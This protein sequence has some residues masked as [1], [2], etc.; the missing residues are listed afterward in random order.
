[1]ENRVSYSELTSRI[2][3]LEKE[4]QMLKKRHKKAGSFSVE[5][6][7]K[8]RD[9][10]ELLVNER[11]NELK[12]SESKY[13]IFVERSS[14]SIFMIEFGKPVSLEYSEK[15][16]VQEIFNESFFAEC[17][18]AYAQRLGYKHK[19]DLI[20]T[21]VR[22]ILKKED[23]GNIKK[24]ITDFVHSGYKIT[25]LF[26]ESVND[27]GDTVYIL[28]NSVG[29][30]LGNKLTGIWSTQ[31]DITAVKKIEND[32]LYRNHFE[33]LLS[34]ISTQFINIPPENVDNEIVKAL[35]EIAGFIDCDEGHILMFDYEHD[36]FMITHQWIKKEET[37]NT[38][39]LCSINPD[40]IPWM[41]NELIDH[42]I[43]FIP[44]LNHIPQTANKLKI[45]MKEL[46]LN[47]G[48]IMQITLQG[49]P[50]A[51]LCFNSTKKLSEKTD[52]D[53]Y[54]L[55]MAGQIFVNALNRKNSLISLMKSEQN[56]R[57]I[58]NAT[59]ESIFI[60]EIDTGKILDVNKATLDMF[61]Y[62]YDE[63]IGNRAG[64][65][66]AGKSEETSRK[67][68]ALVKKA[69]T[70]RP[71]IFKWMS[72]RKDGSTFWTEVS[73]KSAHIAGSK[74]VLAV[75]R[76]ISER[77]KT[78]EVLQ[79][80]AD[81]FENIQTGIHIYELEDPDD[82]KT[83]RMIAANPAT[84]KLTGVP[85]GEI[86]GKTLDE[87]FP[88]L[89]EKGIPQK[90]FDVVQTKI[91]IE[92]SDIYYSDERVI[93]GAFSVK[94]FPLP[95]NRVGVAFENISERIKAEEELKNTNKYLQGI[96]NTSPTVF[97]IFDLECLS[98]SYVSEKITGITGYTSEEIYRLKDNLKEIIHPEDFNLVINTVSGL[99]NNVKDKTFEFELRLTRK[100]NKMIWV[101]V[102]AI[103]F[104]Y[105]KDGNPSKLL[106]SVYEVTERKLSQH[107]L[108]ESEERYR[109]LFEQA[110]D[111]IL[112]G[113]ED[114]IITNANSS[115]CKISG[116]EKNELINQKIE[117]LFRNN[118]IKAKPLR[119]DLVR[120]GQ[121]V[122]NERYLTRKDGKSIE[123][124]MNTKM[125]ADGRLQA[126]FR[127]ITERKLSER[128][129]VESEQKFRLLFESASDAIFMMKENKFVDCNSATLKMYGC[130]REEILNQTPFRFSPQK[131]PDGRDSLEKGMEKIK[132]AYDGVPQFFEW[133]HIKFDGVH[134][135]AEVALQRIEF[136]GEIYLQ[137][138]VRD[139]TSRKAAENA[140]YE[141]EAQLAEANSMLQ[142][143]LNTIPVRVFWKNSEFKYLGCNKLFAQDAGFDDPFKII[144]MDDYQLSWKSEADLYRA[145][146]RKV[147]S[148][149]VSIMN[150]EEPQTTPD[151]HKIWLKTSKIPLKNATGSTIGVLGTYEDITEMKFMEKKI[152]D[153]IIRT[154]EKEREKF[155][156]NLHDDLGPLLSSI[157]M[158]VN[159]IDSIQEI[160]KQKFIIDQLNEIVKEA[161]QSTK[162][163]SN[164][165]SPHILKNYGLYASIE[166]FARNVEEHIVIKFQSNIADNRFSDE[167]E[168]SL[169]RIIKELINNTIKHAGAAEIQ[170]RIV[171]EGKN[172]RLNFKDNGVG[173]D[174]VNFDQK[175]TLGMGISNIISRVRSLKGR[176]SYLSEP[177]K[178]M[179]F[180][181]N[182][183]V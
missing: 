118:E 61:G 131:Q 153:A 78:E 30:I 55:K 165:L 45:T 20:G 25:N 178:G 125:L 176:Y 102:S 86:I 163:I 80:A 100:D 21:P 75:I 127:D 24:L 31:R 52:T 13:R 114:G 132:A 138:I 175:V 71:Q 33:R 65:L 160:E 89:R 106:A 111:G 135:D 136:S 69:A 133:Q 85:V 166:S 145:D 98:I 42:E 130:S 170:L 97:V 58:F 94:A 92:I 36:K 22:T 99:K 44:S 6:L 57:E 63:I 3:F 117:M 16:Q 103:I 47:A 142:I 27:D 70:K 4:N 96:I 122:I 120:S 181:L 51:L 83:L 90:Y 48:I 14:E 15:K 141:R 162:E 109:T 164:D 77:K 46:G 87:N 2:K 182:I 134:F 62:S 53:F 183:P 129:L 151:G 81:L 17:N 11:S 40:E 143:I 150:Y 50:L 32:L 49:F 158:Y 167:I 140:L 10:L 29:I 107:A 115:M 146:D 112:V 95:R 35:G 105:N 172:L 64:D 1:M 5:E 23:C 180:E 113:N 128:A 66:S 104:E 177:G 121:N 147:L 152:L 26:L 88:G 110:A 67:A 54:L 7:E 41:N 8:Y 39:K 19:E 9:Y 59:S 82:N 37:F 74:R 34:G 169:Y 179:S 148:D 43:V 76:D 154:E 73:L 123:V 91:P 168:T 171:L 159:T 28:N 101:S 119:Y 93:S 139:I 156:K 124:E 84:E 108:M 38:K 68:L 149:A 12:Q 137:A 144:G 60:H 174:Y 155:A 157:K 18:L 72:K 173:F 161:I 79:Q 56:Y 116:F 126:L